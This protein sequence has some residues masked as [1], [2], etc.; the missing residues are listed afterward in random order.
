MKLHYKMLQEKSP[1]SPSNQTALLNSP[2]TE[3]VGL[4]LISCL[5]IICG[6]SWQWRSRGNIGKEKWW[7]R[8][9][10]RIYYEENTKLTESNVKKILN[11]FLKLL[12]FILWQKLFIKPIFSFFW[13]YC[14]LQ[15]YLMLDVTMYLVYRQLNVI[16]NNVCHFQPWPSETN[17]KKLLITL[18]N[19]FCFFLT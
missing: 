12:Y 19:L 8:M 10:A 1:N 2:Y 17:K 7:K 9:A 3:L 16:N 11:L 6:T 18:L 4:P 13:E 15:Y 14:I 5:I